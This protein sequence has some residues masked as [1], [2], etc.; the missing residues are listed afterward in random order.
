[1]PADF[2][3][4][5]SRVSKQFRDNG[6]VPKDAESRAFAICTAQ[7]KRAGKPFREE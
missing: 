7:F 4:C 2:D 3:R 5:V 6:I 1:M